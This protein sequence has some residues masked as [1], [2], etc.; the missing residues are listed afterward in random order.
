MRK[1]QINK[2]VLIVCILFICV[3]CRKQESELKVGF[4]SGNIMEKKDGYNVTEGRIEEEILIAKESI[5]DTTSPDMDEGSAGNST[6]GE[7]QDEILEKRIV[8]EDTSQ[9]G[10]HETEN[11]YYAIYPSTIVENDPADK[12]N[13][14]FICEKEI[15]ITFPQIYYSNE[16][17]EYDRKIETAV[18]HEL[19]LASTGADDFL[20]ERDMR[21]LQGCVTDYEITKVDD[22]V[23]SIKYIEECWDIYHDNTFYQGITLDVKTGEKIDLSAYIDLE[24]NLVEQVE[25][26]EIELISLGHEWEDVKDSIYWFYESYQNGEEDTYSCYYLEEDAINLC[27]ELMQGNAAYVILRIPLKE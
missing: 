15:S 27:V 26:G 12:P 25:N 1:K 17:E 7:E 24:D 21:Q 10:G 3:G 16:Y 18:N 2:I 9:V 8:N 4:V 23:V 13:Q 5:E 20:F 19:F 6:E 11:T 22:E 14:F